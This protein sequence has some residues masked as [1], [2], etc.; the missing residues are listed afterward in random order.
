MTI[1][2]SSCRAEMLPAVPSTSPLRSISLAV[3]RTALGASSTYFTTEPSRQNLRIHDVDGPLPG[4]Q[5][6]HVG[7][8]HG[9]LPGLGVVGAAPDVGGEHHVVHGA[10]RVVGGQVLPLEVVQ[11]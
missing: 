5:P 6:L 1:V 2:P 11:P 8:H 10:E 7:G 9:G 3:A 4:K